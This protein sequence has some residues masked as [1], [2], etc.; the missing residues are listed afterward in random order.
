MQNA[1]RPIRIGGRSSID[2]LP[3]KLREA[4]DQAIADGATIDD[5][6]ALIRAEGGSCSRSAVGRYSRNMR[7][8]I[9]EQHEFDRAM[10][11]WVREL[12]E[13]AEGRAGLILI[14][15][16]RT[17]VL[18]SMAELSQRGEPAPMQELARL[19]LTLKRIEGTDKLR[20]ERERTTAKPAPVGG[21]KP[22]GGL[23]PETAAALRE[24]V[25]GRPGPPDRALTSVPVDAWAPA[26]S[27]PSSLIPPD[28]GQKFPVR[29]GRR[30][31]VRRNSAANLDQAS[32]SR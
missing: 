4:V 22:Q 10:K 32:G 3:S 2:R 28:P 15:T 21:T 7:A 30:A 17:M 20:L 14:E 27:R 8:L 16:L 24:V 1:N 29:S 25:E 9:R 18:T 12:G 19:A 23:S 13:R 5:I 31:G 6:S 26:G 11:I